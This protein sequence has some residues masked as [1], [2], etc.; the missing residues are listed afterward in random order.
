MANIVFPQGLDDILAANSD[1]DASG[2]D[3]HAML[4]LN[5]YNGETK[6]TQE[7]DQFASDVRATYEA[8]GTAPDVQLVT[9]NYSVDQEVANDR[10]GW[11]Y[12][13]DLP[14]FT[15]IDNAQTVNGNIFYRDDAGGDTSSPLICFCNFSGGDLA[16][17]GSD[18]VVTP[19][20]SPS[21]IFYIS[22]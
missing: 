4:V 21:F 12:T 1:L 15:S 17:N 10:V 22:Y 16:T 20:A 11:D 7:A 3:M 18:V 14:T 13:A 9:T 5:T 19:S 6:A 2:G 8:S